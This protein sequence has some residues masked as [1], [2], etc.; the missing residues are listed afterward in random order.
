MRRNMIV[1][2]ITMPSAKYF[3]SRSSAS[4]AFC[5][6]PKVTAVLEAIP[7][8]TPVTATP[9]RAPSKRIST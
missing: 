9:R 7:P 2:A 5:E 3:A 6:R 8:S 4:C 1:E